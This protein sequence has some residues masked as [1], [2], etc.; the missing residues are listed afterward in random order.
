LSIE[1]AIE[2]YR[3]EVTEG[4]TL[5]FSRD[6]HGIHV[7]AIDDLDVRETKQLNLMIASASV[8]D[9]RPRP[10]HNAAPILAEVILPAAL[11][12]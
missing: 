12:T 8:P 11:S 4:G 3:S 9:R 6:E 5:R 7:F 2:A 1:L 10:L